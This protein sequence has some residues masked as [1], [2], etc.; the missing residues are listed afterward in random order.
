[1]NMYKEE[2]FGPARI[3]V[4]VDTIEEAI[5]LINGHQYGNGVTVFPS[6]GRGRHARKFTQEIEVGMVGVIVPISIPV[7]YHNFGGWKGSR[8]GEGQMFRLDTARFFTKTK[9]VSERWFD[10]DDIESETYFDFPS[11]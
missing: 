1:M 8:Y 9:T 7:G 2:V 11:S 4:N 6:S 5:N 3:I 10:L